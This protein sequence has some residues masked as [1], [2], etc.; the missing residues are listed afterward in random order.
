LLI[1]FLVEE[2]IVEEVEN[3]PD[4]REDDHEVHN[5][6]QQRPGQFSGVLAPMPPASIGL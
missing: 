2:V 4:K 1:L 3:D 6:R 5:M